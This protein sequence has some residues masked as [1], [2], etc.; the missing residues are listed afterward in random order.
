[1]GDLGEK[2]D[3]EASRLGMTPDEVGNKASSLLHAAHCP[4]FISTR[5]SITLMEHLSR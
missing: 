3:I 1:M 5:F 2:I 4:T